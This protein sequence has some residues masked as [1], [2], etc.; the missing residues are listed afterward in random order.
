MPRPNMARVTPISLGLALSWRSSRG[1]AIRSTPVARDEKNMAPTRAPLRLLIRSRSG[2]LVGAMFF[3][4]LATGVLLIAI[5]LELR[6]LN[7]SPNEIGVTLAMFG[8]GMFLFEW[9][10]GVLA[11]RVGYGVPLAVSQVLYGAVIVL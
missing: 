10:W 2:A 1:M 7:A 4:S 3:S 5:P 8:L 9:V 6:Q 11:D